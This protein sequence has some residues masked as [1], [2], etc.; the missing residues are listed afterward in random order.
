MSALHHQRHSQTWVSDSLNVLL[1]VLLC[2]LDILATSLEFN[3][4]NLPKDLKVSA[5]GHLEATLL[6]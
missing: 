2:N 4:S 6:K 1:L 5:E 3:F